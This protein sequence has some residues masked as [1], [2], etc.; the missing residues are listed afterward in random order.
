[1]RPL[2]HGC[3]ASTWRLTVDRCYL[4]IVFKGIREQWRTD[5]RLVWFF[6]NG[7]A[8]LILTAITLTRGYV[9]W[10]AA[11]LSVSYFVGYAVLT[12]RAIRRD[13]SAKRETGR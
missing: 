9:G 4:S 3:S 2:L 8:L 5:R 7:A 6:G 1:M 10:I 13:A 12:R 11:A